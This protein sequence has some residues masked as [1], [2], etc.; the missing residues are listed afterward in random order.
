MDGCDGTIKEV[1]SHAGQS[2]SSDELVWEDF[3]P[4]FSVTMGSEHKLRQPGVID[5]SCTRWV[6]G[7]IREIT[8]WGF[9]C[10]I[11]LEK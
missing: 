11:D 9:V 7:E 5:S 8:G 2:R 6:K 10:R 4:I 1:V 3:D